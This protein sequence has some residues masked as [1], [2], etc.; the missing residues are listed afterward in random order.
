VN[1]P[2]AFVRAQTALAAPPLVPEIRLH[3]AAEVTP[4]WRATESTLAASGLPPPYWA[5]A[6]PGGQALARHLLDHPVFV[7]DR[8]VLDFAAGSGLAAI[9]A[10][11]A[12]AL[13]VAAADIDTFA[14]AAIGLNAAANGITLNIIGDDL[15]DR[16]NAWDVVLAG[17]VC[18][19][20]PLAERATAWLRGLASAGALVLL[21][22]PGRS[23]LPTDGLT[24]IARY[25]V[26]TSRELE[27][28]EL[29][30]TVIWR[31]SAG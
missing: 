16:P 11:K 29:R 30:E 12:G 6:W 22:D 19:E 26:P 1:N 24:E 17:D 5:F 8:R 9:A 21:A 20:R 4:L 28:Q 27:D 7:R 2:A 25:Q 31:L 13:S 15:I 10:A 14:L 3:L 23:Y 18:Y